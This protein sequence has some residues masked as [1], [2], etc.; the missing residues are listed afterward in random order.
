MVGGFAGESG[1]AIDACFSLGNVT[2][3]GADSYTGGLVGN[4]TG[5]LSNCYSYA[6]A[7]GTQFTA[8]LVG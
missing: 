5:T 2:A 4:L 6:K 3:S 1:D 8:G 7:T